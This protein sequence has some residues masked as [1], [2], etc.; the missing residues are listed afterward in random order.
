[1]VSKSKKSIA[2]TIVVVII[3]S[4]ILTSSINNLQPI[5]SGL[6]GP[7][8]GPGTSNSGTGSGNGISGSGGATT[9]NLF[10]FP[11]LNFNFNLP[12]LNFGSLNLP[13]L[14]V[15]N[16]P[17]I[18][19]QLPNFKLNLFGTPHQNQL[20]PKNKT[21]GS[22]SGTGQKTS[23]NSPINPII[24][25]EFILLI[26]VGILAFVMAVWLILR[27]KRGGFLER[28][29]KAPKIKYGEQ[30]YSV[31]D[32]FED[33]NIEREHLEN[34]REEEKPFNP[35]IF[36]QKETIMTGW[37][38]KGLIR[39]MIAEDLPL[40]WALN[41][42]LGIAMDPGTKMELSGAD[43]VKTD[44]DH[45]YISL[46]NRCAELSTKYS[47]QS[48][49][50]LI[51]GVEYDDDIKD[52]FRLNMKDYL[53]KEN[54]SLTFREMIKSDENLKKILKQKDEFKTALSAF[55]KIFYGAKNADRKVYEAFL[56][57]LMRG[58]YKPK[59]FTCGDNQ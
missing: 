55:E 44:S 39:P 51:R 28:I 12:S 50:K 32:L 5:Q 34:K 18:H 38:G 4:W 42:P 57:G 9:G 54:Q 7:T 36:P 23:S 41:S 59:I 16:I 43:I 10:N 45:T 17:F 11:N 25:N 37:G 29:Q 26:I 8:S 22:N 20:P 53:N 52:V 15:F 3:A 40:S 27:I 46:K 47:L 6:N 33:K 30:D 14:P 13:N 56:R 49:R 19:F 1:M 2:I 21:G 31:S 58:I 24:I 35:F 48:E